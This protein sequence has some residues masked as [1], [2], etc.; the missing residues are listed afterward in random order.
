[1]PNMPHQPETGLLLS[2]G[3]DSAVLLGQLLARGW[4]VVPFYV[5]SGCVWES[6]EL[7]SVRRFLA[8]LEQ[9]GLRPLVVLDMPLD[10]LYGD[11][12]SLSGADVPDDHT[13]DEAVYLPGHNPLLLIK[14]AVWCRMHGIGHLTLA[15]LSNNPF[16]DATPAFFAQFE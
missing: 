13:P 7:D 1:M 5:R 9:P 16:P 12:W 4:Q 14:P 2:G 15:T 3:I 6:S 10:D 11:H 8:K